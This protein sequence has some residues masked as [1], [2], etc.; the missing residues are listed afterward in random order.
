MDKD[1]LIADLR[2]T[3]RDLRQSHRKEALKRRIEPLWSDGASDADTGK[4]F[5]AICERYDRET[6]NLCRMWEDEESGQ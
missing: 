3:I 5:K 1:R 4:A 2:A 6:E